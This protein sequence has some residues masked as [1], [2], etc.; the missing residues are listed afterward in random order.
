MTK[1]Q[2]HS[3]SD[4]YGDKLK[5]LKVGLEQANNLSIQAETRLEELSRQEKEII[6]QIRALGVEPDRLEEELALLEGEIT[7]LIGEIE[8]LI[9]WGLLEEAPTAKGR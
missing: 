6:E 3:N 1:Q 4:P 9:P 2:P 8:E 7:A 5:L